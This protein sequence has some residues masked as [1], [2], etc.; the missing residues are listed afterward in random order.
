MSPLISIVIPVYNTEQYIAETIQSVIDQ[1]YENW[2][3]LLVDDGSTDGSAT[4]IKSFAEN[5]SRIHYFYK[6]NGGQ[7]SARNEGIKKSKGTYVGFLDADDL[8]LKNKLAQQI[9]ELGIY[10]PDFLYGL[11]Y[12]YYP[13]KEPQLETYD[14]INGERSG[15]DFF[16]ELYHSCAVNTNTVL[17]KRELFDSVGYFDEN[18]HLRGTEDWDLWM[19]IAK[20][21]D[22]V[23]GS[24]LRLVYYRIHEGGIHLQHTRMLIGKIAIYDKYERDHIIPKL[25]RKREYRYHYRELFNHLYKDGRTNEIKSF[26]SEFVKKD[27]A[28]FG[29]FIQRIIFPFV[30]KPTFVW[31]S[32]KLIYRVAYRIE[33]I[34]YKLYLK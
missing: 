34:T 5:D 19:R 22:K 29:T 28:G 3:L 9:K 18:Q 13:E 7:A 23:Y 11:G 21:V 26:F 6:E 31:I 24:P 1:T 20:T 25:M 14:W 4:I 30:S 2:E 12:Y 16:K 8:W 33:K 32:N 27:R 17:V 15:L 10:Q